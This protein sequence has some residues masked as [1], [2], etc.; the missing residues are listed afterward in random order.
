MKR[1]ADPTLAEV[2]ET[3]AAVGLMGDTLKKIQA[4]APYT[5]WKFCGTDIGL[6]GAQLRTAQVQQPI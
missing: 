1:I 3:A 5:R 6:V 4:N 2:L